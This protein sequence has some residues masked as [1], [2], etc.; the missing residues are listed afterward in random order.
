MQHG[1]REVELRSYAPKLGQLVASVLPLQI[2]LLYRGVLLTSIS[3]LCSRWHAYYHGTSHTQSFPN[4]SSCQRLLAGTTNSD[5][6]RRHFTGRCETDSLYPNKVTWF[7]TPILLPEQTGCQG[8]AFFRLPTLYCLN[9]TCTPFS[10][11]NSEFSW[12]I[13]VT[14]L[15][16]EDDTAVF[17]DSRSLGSGPSE[18]PGRGL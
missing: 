16:H 1:C 2:E 17:D 3:Q 18:G 15:V 13:I 7:L 14:L 12:S 9:K 5:R 11:Y 6:Y 4:C 10:F 8:K